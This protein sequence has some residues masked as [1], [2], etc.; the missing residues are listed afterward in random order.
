MSP[1][2]WVAAVQEDN[3]KAIEP[4]KKVEEEEE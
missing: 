3:A 4:G 1:Q 2:E